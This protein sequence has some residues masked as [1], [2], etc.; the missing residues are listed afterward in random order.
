VIGIIGRLTAVKNHWAFLEA[1]A[2]I[3]NERPEATFV[4]AGD[5]E[6]RDE[7]SQRARQLLGDRCRFLGWVVDLP[8]LYAAID[9]V[10]LTSRNE[11]TPVALIEAAAARRPVVA[12]RVGAI[13]DVV[14]DGTTGLLAPS[15]E[16]ASIA[17]QVL[18]LLDAPGLTTNM[19]AAGR[20]WVRDRFA[21]D[22]LA[23]DLARLYEEFL[24]RKRLIPRGPRGT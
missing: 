23:D 22:R 1:A 19:G 13:G 20:E 24:M 18:R 14:K 9:V 6:L 15:G 17:A 5:G 7:L 16:P 10:V 21:L 4:I 8:T 12:T 11:G 3:A 2:R